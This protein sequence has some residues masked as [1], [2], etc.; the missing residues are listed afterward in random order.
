VARL[1]SK[2]SPE[3]FY[4]EEQ[5]KTVYYEE[6][7][8]LLKSKL[9]AQRV[10]IL[11]HAV[12]KV[13]R[14]VFRDFFFFFLRAS[15]TPL[16]IRKRHPEFPISTGEDYDYLQPTSVVHIGKETPE[17]LDNVELL[18]HADFTPESALESSSQ[19]LK[20][21]HS[22][23]SRIQSVKYGNLSPL[24]QPHIPLTSILY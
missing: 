14:P 13:F 3:D 21:S 22:N 2:L 5:L 1:E 9:G 17:S 4:S 6:L 11:E 16:K 24:S 23:Y 10:E 18:N 8:E 19:V 12:S 7:R 15:L 20:V